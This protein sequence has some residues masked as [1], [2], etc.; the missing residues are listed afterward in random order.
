MN[1]L[2]RIV[3]LALLTGSVFAAEMVP[4]YNLVSLQAEARRAVTNDLASASL[5]VEY[6]DANAGA[7]SD[8]LNRSAAEALKT[9]KAYP[10]VKAAANGNSV[11]P[12]YSSKNRLDGWRGRA[13]IRLES[14]DFKAIGEL[15]GKLQANMQLGGIQFTVAPVTRERVETELM[16]EAIQAFRSRAEVVKKSVGGKSYK[17]VNL[18]L[19]T[20]SSYPQPMYKA[21]AMRTMA[22]A[23]VAPPPMEGGDSEVVVGVSGS[24]E[25]Q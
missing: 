4:Q 25:V 8:K 20:S 22:V 14:T 10:S 6:N 11:Y 17:L 2:A 21:G 16:D 9:A 19:N 13:E 24:V 12:I 15:V 3:T 18:N 23:D 1:K 7:L 5:Y